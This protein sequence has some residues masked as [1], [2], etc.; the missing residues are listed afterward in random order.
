[1]KKITVTEEIAGN[2]LDKSIASLFPEYSRSAIEKLIESNQIC[3]N[4]EPTKTKYLLKV[5]DVIELDFNELDKEPEAIELPVI[6]ED[7]NVI[8]VHKPLGV[9]AHTKGNFSKEGTVASFI[10]SKLTGTDEW[11]SSNRAGIVHRLDRATSG[12]MICAKNEEA[13]SF[14]GKQFSERNVKKTYAAIITGELS[15]PEG[16]IDVPIERNPKKPATFRAGVNGKAAQTTFATIKSNQKHSLVELKPYTGRTH[17][18][19]V[20]LNYLKHPIVGDEFYNGEKAERL[21]LHAHALEITIPGGI[22]KI[23]TAPLP[24]IFNTYF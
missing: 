2:R 4:K 16:T 19:R 15:V 18:L 6:F 12:V 13:Q 11:K 17:Q 23:F 8:V 10:N 1:V 22:R 9:L 24:E 3:V 5:G 14:L 21:M 20:H 7:E